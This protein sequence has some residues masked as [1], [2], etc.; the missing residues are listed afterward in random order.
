M[1]FTYNGEQTGTVGE[2]KQI[3]GRESLTFTKAM[4]FVF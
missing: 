3:I 2:T 1:T 4:T